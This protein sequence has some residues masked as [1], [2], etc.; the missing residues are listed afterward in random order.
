MAD[1]LGT[2]EANEMYTAIS[3]WLKDGKLR[4]KVDVRDGLENIPETFNLLFSGRHDGKL[5]VKVANPS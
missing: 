3:R 5:I 1:C 4:Y 2:P